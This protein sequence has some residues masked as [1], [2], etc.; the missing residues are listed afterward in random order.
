MALLLYL[1]GFNSSPESKKAVTLKDWLQ[2]HYPEIDMLVPCIPPYPTSA[3]ALLEDIVRAGQL[4]GIIGTSL[5]GYYATWLSQKFRLPT[6]VINPAV[7]P[8]ECVTDYLGEYENPYSGEQYRLETSHFADLKTIH[9]DSLR[10]PE[11]LWLLQQT[12]DE[13]FDW[14]H[15]VAYYSFCRQT[16]EVGGNHA[17]THFERYFMP[18][19]NFLGL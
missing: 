3:I 18:I 10:S 14:R 19:V 2:K 1:H 7:R 9:H 13:V 17:F 4:S 11:L 16:V 15:A 8:F 6:V 12:G 5:G